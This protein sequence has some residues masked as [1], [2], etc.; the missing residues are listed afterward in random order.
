MSFDLPKCQPK[1]LDDM[2]KVP[3]QALVSVRTDDSFILNSLLSD[4]HPCRVVRTSEIVSLTTGGKGLMT[5]LI[6]RKEM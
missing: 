4:L 1:F 6:T 2:V 3:D 5:F